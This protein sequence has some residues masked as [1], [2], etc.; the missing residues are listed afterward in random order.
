MASAK[1]ERRILVLGSADSGRTTLIK[2]ICGENIQYET[3]PGMEYE[4][5]KC[6]DKHLTFIET[7]EFKRNKKSWD[8]IQ[9]FI[10][11]DLLPIHA[12]WLVLHYQYD[13]DDNALKTLTMLPYL[14]S[15]II[16]NH[17]DFLQTSFYCRQELEKDIKHFDDANQK[18]PPAYLQSSPIL[19]AQRERLIKWKANNKD[20]VNLQRIFLTSL[21]NQEETDRPIGVRTVIEETISIIDVFQQKQ[22]LLVILKTKI[23]GHET[24]SNPWNRFQ[25]KHAEKGCLEEDI[26]AQYYHIC[27]G[28]NDF[29]ID[30]TII[31]V[32]RRTGRDT[33]FKIKILQSD[34]FHCTRFALESLTVAVPLVEAASILPH[35]DLYQKLSSY[36]DVDKLT[37]LGLVAEHFLQWLDMGYNDAGSLFALIP[38][39]FKYQIDTCP[40]YHEATFELQ[41]AKLGLTSD[42]VKFIVQQTTKYENDDKQDAI[43]YAL[44]YYLHQFFVIFEITLDPPITSTPLNQLKPLDIQ[45]SKDLFPGKFQTIRITN[46]RT[47]DINIS[48]ER[49]EIIQQK[50]SEKI[51]FHA[52]QA[53]QAVNILH[54]GLDAMGARSNLDFG[55]GFYLNIYFKDASDFC[56]RHIAPYADHQAAILI[57]QVPAQVYNTWNIYEVDYT[58]LEQNLDNLTRW[59]HFVRDC[60]R[61]QINNR[62]RHEY[63]GFSGPQCAN[64]SKIVSELLRIRYT[65]ETKPRVAWQI[66]LHSS[67]TQA[68]IMDYLT[69]VVTFT[70][71]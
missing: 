20:A 10:R 34:A 47:N 52:T 24:P 61:R 30:D 18:N 6:L 21:R 36:R 59:Q 3:M 51:L 38:A 33:V 27:L 62:A 58:T 9:E 54:F 55:P 28:E 12:I 35:D 65:N 4:Q 64:P 40:N 42:C 29:S 2:T 67:N 15:F 71:I 25:K 22:V 5:I 23:I 31:D 44:Q 48:L 8:E 66:S 45:V 68:R 60:R 11:N 16:L 41:L 43:Y 19:M 53:Q 32:I 13:I 7:P 50:G 17:A 1:T 26:T 14:P 39:Y 37:Q 69:S 70:D 56:Q 57:F 46:F 63:D 49:T